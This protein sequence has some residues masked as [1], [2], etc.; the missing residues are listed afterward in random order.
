VQKVEG[1]RKKTILAKGGFGTPSYARQAIARRR[2]QGRG[3]EPDGNQRLPA[4]HELA[5]TLSDCGPFY[6]FIFFK[7][8]FWEV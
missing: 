3:P 8:F 5:L 2:P 1:M 6:I 4:G 7:S